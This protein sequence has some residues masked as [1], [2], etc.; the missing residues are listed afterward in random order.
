VTFGLPQV[1]L[2]QGATTPPPQG[3]KPAAPAA[4]AATASAASTATPSAPTA[5]P[6]APAAAPTA[7]AAAPTAPAAAPTAPAAAPTSPAAAPVAPP[8]STEPPKP[9]AETLTGEALAEYESASLLYRDGDYAGAVT[10]FNHAYDLAHDPRLLWNIAVCEK[11]L[12]HYASVQRLVTRY[13][14]EGGAFLTAEDRASAEAL[15]SAIASFVSSLTVN[16]NPAGAAV[17]VDG[18][19]V[20][21][22]PLPEALNVDM[23]SHV[24]GA[25]LEGYV[26]QKRTIEL[27]GGRATDVSFELQEMRHEGKLRVFA[28]PREE[29]YIDGK[30][31]GIGQWE[32]VLPSGVHRV[33][34]TAPEKKPYESDVSVVDAEVSSVNVSLSD[35]EKQQSSTSPWLWI[36]GGAAVAA[37]AGLGGYYLFRSPNDPKD[38]TTVG[39]ISPGQVSLD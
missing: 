3:T 37:G 32:G 11:N 14:A 2:A 35:I 28:G 17:I 6:S 20:G 18:R 10:K 19:V 29:I 1:A 4:A 24:I 33:R 25:Q 5:A 21:K 8:A 15:L 30:I 7:P 12:R 31:A 9:L 23:G 26:E 22:S 38:T 13:L 16:V 27:V 36:L 39:T 34:V